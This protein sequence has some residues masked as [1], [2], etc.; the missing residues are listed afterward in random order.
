MHLTAFKQKI[1]T[2]TLTACWL[3]LVFCLTPAHGMALPA[4]VK[5]THWAAPFVQEALDNNLMSLP[6]GKE[7]HGEAKVTHS[8]AVFALA[9][10]AQMLEANK[11]KAMKSRPVSDKTIET[12]EHGDWR[13]QKVT[14]YELAKVLTSMGDY[15]AN[16]LPRPAPG[17]KDLSKST[18]LPPKPVLKLDKSNPA[19]AALKYLVDADMVTPDSPLLK[20]DSKLLLG[21]ELSHALAAMVIGLN[22]RATELGLDEDGSTHDV[23][24]KPKSPK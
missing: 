17:A 24:S 21:V 1:K 12:L 5:T 10:L 11:W 18:V 3:S 9:K 22:N 2:L 7:F 23:N 4:D 19:Y 16:G 8:E 14:R 20:A 13:T 15:I 6:D